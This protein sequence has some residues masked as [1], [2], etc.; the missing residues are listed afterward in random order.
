ME[1]FVNGVHSG[2]WEFHQPPEV[3]IW[4][5]R[6]RIPADIFW[7]AQPVH[8]AFNINE[9][10]KSPQEMRQGA[11]RRKLGLAFLKLHIATAE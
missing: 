8:V 10:L 5:E 7:K 4:T 3:G 2:R 11:G 9:P 1:I 6:L